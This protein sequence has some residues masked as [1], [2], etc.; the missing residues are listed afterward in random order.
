LNDIEN[1]QA[2]GFRAGGLI[3]QKGQNLC[4]SVVF[5]TAEAEVHLWVWSS[6]FRL[7][8]RQKFSG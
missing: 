2:A 6:G 3:L 5:Q 4:L 7:S 8:S 1:N